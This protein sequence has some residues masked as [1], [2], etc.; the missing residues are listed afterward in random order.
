MIIYRMQASF[1]CLNQQSLE[2]T[3][4]LNLLYAPNESGKSTWC[5]FLLAMLYGLNTRARDKRGAPAEKNRY[6]PLSGAPM[7]GLLECSYAG[8]RIILRRSSAQGI[9]MGSFSA[10]YADSG[11][12][13]PGLTGENVGEQLTGVGREVFERTLLIRQT[14]LAVEQSSELEQRIHALIS[15]GDEGHSWSSADAKL[16]EWQ[17]AL[18]YHK[19]GQLPLLEE[20]EQALLGKI[21]Q[22][23]S[24]WQEHLLLKEQITQEEAVLAVIDAQDAKASRREEDEQQLRWAEAAAELD[25]AQLTLKTLEEGGGAAQRD[26][27]DALGE[28]IHYLEQ[29]ARRRGTALHLVSLLGLLLLGVFFVSYRY[30]TLLP[31]PILLPLPT[32]SPYIYG[33]VALAYL[34]LWLE[35]LLRR[36]S[37]LKQMDELQDQLDAQWE[38]DLQQSVEREAALLR[39][40]A[41]QKVFDSLS[42]EQKTCRH[43][44]PEALAV[45]D[46]LTQKRQQLAHLTGRLKELGD[47]TALEAALE[48]NRR[49]QQQLSEQYAALGEAISA[50]QGAELELRTRFSPALNRSTARYFSRLTGGAY[51]DVTLDRDFSAAAE[52]SGSFALQSAALFSQ[53]TADQLYLSLR[54]ALCDLVLPSGQAVPLILDDALSSFD[55]RRAALALSLLKERAGRQQILLF[56]CHK[57]EAAILEELSEAHT[58]APC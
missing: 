48:E 34:S 41:A 53:G 6:R 22:L 23:S 20:E 49:Q 38:Q 21:A 58:L 45:E 17:R 12:P 56:T 33:G 30:P 18:R 25:A 37:F 16:R 15:S 24:L 11:E 14:N 46:R 44:S 31:L 13:V 47:L 36:R 1:G 5:A 9:P 54:L 19:S 2:L 52:P 40:E 39:V 42:Q 57:R 7:E 35:L 8:R 4:G 43:R 26:K 27:R 28:E 29:K 50:L 55:D 51:Q 3:E 10:L 32:L